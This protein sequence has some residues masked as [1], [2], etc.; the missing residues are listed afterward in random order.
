MPT[1]R[2]VAPARP[3]AGAIGLALIVAGCA[4]GPTPETR[5]LAGFSKAD[6]QAQ[7]FPGASEVMSGLSLA[8]AYR[9]QA[10]IVGARQARGDRVV[11]YK[12]GLMSAK[13]LADKAAAEPL[14]GALFASGDLATGARVSLCAYRRAALEMKLGYVFAAPV[15]GRLADVEALKAKVRSVQPVVELPDIAYRNGETY[16]AVDMAAANISSAKFVRGGPQTVSA[17]D[18]DALPVTLRRD[19]VQLTRGLGRDSLGGQWTSLLT[20]VNLVTAHGG[21]IGAGQ[22]VLTGKIGDKATLTPGAYQ[23]DYGPLGAVQFQVDACQN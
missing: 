10:R 2:A 12:G 14:T 19:G 20:V 4:A 7:T 22:L 16:P 15:T 8:D 1:R 21:R 11:G 9:L 6:R 23:A 5:Y 13:S 3:F 18:L 17:T